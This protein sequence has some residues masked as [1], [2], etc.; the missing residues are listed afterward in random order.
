M[1]NFLE[2]LNLTSQERRIVMA[3]GLVVIVV[4]NLLFVWPHF[5]EWG[6]TQRQL[7]QMYKTIADYNKAIAEDIDPTNGLRKQVARLEKIEGSSHMDVAVQLP[8]TIRDIAIKN[9]VFVNDFTPLGS[10]RGPTNEFFEEQ[11]QQI[12][13]ESEEPALINFLYQI[14]NDPS[15]IRVAE[16]ELGPADQN[17]YKFRGRITL[18]ANYAKKP[19]APVTK[20]KTGKP[21]PPGAKSPGEAKQPPGTKSPAGQKPG[22]PPGPGQRPGGPGAPGQ[23]PG[24]PPGPGQKPGANPNARP[25]PNTPPGQAPPRRNL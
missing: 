19:P 17:R 13:I 25:N 12:N 9:K 5:G 1:N 11:S 3:I 7:D 2:Q 24:G 4:L 8:Q 6:R 20:A 16:L 18:T 23:R 22:G 10:G 21:G 15:M 14:G